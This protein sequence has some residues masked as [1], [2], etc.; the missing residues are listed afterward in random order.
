MWEPHKIT[1]E[2]SRSWITGYRG[3]IK[4]SKKGP[5]H[6]IAFSRQEA[7]E[8]SYVADNCYR[9]AEMVRIKAS[10]AQLKQIESILSEQNT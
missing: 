2:N 10:Y 6:G 8:I 3:S 5:N 7:D 1:G 9:V 4:I